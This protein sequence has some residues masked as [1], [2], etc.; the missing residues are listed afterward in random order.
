[1]GFFVDFSDRDKN[2]TKKKVKSQNFSIKL[3]TWRM[4]IAISD[5]FATIS[6]KIKS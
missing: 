1:M 3:L 5:L 2:R 4:R 6:L